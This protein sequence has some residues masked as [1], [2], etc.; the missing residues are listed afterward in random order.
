MR[1]IRGS[2]LTVEALDVRE[3]FRVEQAYTTELSRS[4]EAAAARRA[5]FEA[6]KR[7]GSKT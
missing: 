3:G 4:P 6:R 5:F 7:P 1:R 2:F